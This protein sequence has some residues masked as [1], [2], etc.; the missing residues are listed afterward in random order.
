MELQLADSQLRNWLHLDR[1]R[2]NIVA[3]DSIVLESSKERCKQDTQREAIVA[4]STSDKDGGRSMVRVRNSKFNTTSCPSH[5]A[6]SH[7][8]KRI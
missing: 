3:R 8:P 4:G 2:G 6:T 1:G 5:T 7:L